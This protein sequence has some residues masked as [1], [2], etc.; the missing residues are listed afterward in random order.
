MLEAI[1][2]TVIGMFIG[3]HIPQPDVAKVI[4]SKLASI[5]SRPQ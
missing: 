5:F 2:F 1:F 4:W 3:W